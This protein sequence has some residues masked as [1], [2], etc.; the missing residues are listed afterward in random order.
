MMSLKSYRLDAIIINHMSVVDRSVKFAMFSQQLVIGVDVL[1]VQDL[2]EVE[3]YSDV[4]VGISGR[5]TANV[6]EK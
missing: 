6:L 5:V 3:R 1:G 4:N 2:A